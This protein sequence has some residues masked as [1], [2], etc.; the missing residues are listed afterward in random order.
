MNYRET[1]M[2]QVLV[3][4]AEEALLHLSYMRLE[5]DPLWDDLEAALAP[6]RPDCT[7]CGMSAAP[8]MHR[9]SAPYFCGE[10]R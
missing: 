8:P 4:A 6:F 1:E 9:N 7:T 10:G 5:R 2:V 3:Q